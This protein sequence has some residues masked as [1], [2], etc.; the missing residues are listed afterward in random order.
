M[1]CFSLDSH[2]HIP[3]EI[4]AAR[5]S[6]NREFLFQKVKPRSCIFLLYWGILFVQEQ[7]MQ[8]NIPDLKNIFSLVF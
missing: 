1:T 7:T 3:L 2:N 5:I 8:H 4:T 6:I